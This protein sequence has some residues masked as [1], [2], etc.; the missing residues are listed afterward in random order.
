MSS[1][2]ITV[3]LHQSTQTHAL[4]P[5]GLICETENCVDKKQ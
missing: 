1:E 3:I 5:E 4:C 2:I